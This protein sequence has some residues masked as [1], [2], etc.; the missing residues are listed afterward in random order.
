MS[1]PHPTDDTL[2]DHRSLEAGTIL[3]VTHAF[4][5]TRGDELDLSPGEL[6]TV[7]ECPDGGW[8]KG[9]KGIETKNPTTGWFPVVV[10]KVFNQ[11][12]NFNSDEALPSNDAA[13]PIGHK[14]SRSNSIFGKALRLKSDE[15]ISRTRSTSAPSHG[16]SFHSLSLSND[17]ESVADASIVSINLINT[18]ND[19]PALKLRDS[20]RKDDSNR[21]S[22]QP[23]PLL[24]LKGSFSSPPT[25]EYMALK[26]LADTEWHYLQDL[27]LIRVI[28]K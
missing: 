16:T 10:S 24:S 6:I 25:K 20:D 3:Q 5:K 2:T 23:R 17:L 4:S 27:Y 1:E 21:S 15:K 26:E 18:T 22:A 12:D 28:H 8:C 19:I 11:P 7:L 9:V 14:R 13:P